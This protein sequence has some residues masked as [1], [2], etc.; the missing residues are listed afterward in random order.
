MSTGEHWPVAI[1]PHSEYRPLLPHFSP[2]LLT[3]GHYWWSS[4]PVSRATSCCSQSKLR[5]KDNNEIDL[6]GLS[7]S[8]HCSIDIQINII[9]MQFYPFLLQWLYIED[10]TL[11]FQSLWV[12]I[13]TPNHNVTVISSIHM[14]TSDCRPHSWLNPRQESSRSQATNIYLAG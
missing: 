2:T 12:S 8:H 11:P 1:K 3:V 13:K 7:C 4:P 5:Y 14:Q 6:E 10:V 9:F